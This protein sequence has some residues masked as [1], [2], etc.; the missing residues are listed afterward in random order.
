MIINACGKNEVL[1]YKMDTV[2]LEKN[3]E[4]NVS[5]GYD[6]YVYIDKKNFDIY[7]SYSRNTTIGKEH[8][9]EKCDVYV[10][11]KPE[12]EIECRYGVGKSGNVENSFGSYIIKFKTEFN[13]VDKLISKFN[14]ETR[15]LDINVIRDRFN[16]V[17]SEALS[18]DDVID[19][20]SARNVLTKVLSNKFDECGLELKE[21]HIEGINFN[22]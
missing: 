18:R 12:N 9:G 15:T 6:A 20:E 5:R 17:V 21:V 3:N 2:I 1:A 19:E 13:A 10:V 16:A 14:L 7:D 8:K 22:R 11:S 4:I